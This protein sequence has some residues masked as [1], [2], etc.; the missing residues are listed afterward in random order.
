M[1]HAFALASAVDSST[2]SPNVPRMRLRREKR[3]RV[4]VPVRVSGVD[5]NGVPLLD[6]E[7]L[8]VKL[9]NVC[10]EYIGRN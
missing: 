10:A 7:D 3:L 2:Q 1:L 5:A 8:S 4:T 6:W 9:R